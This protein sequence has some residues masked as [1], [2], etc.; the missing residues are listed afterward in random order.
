MLSNL[1]MKLPINKVTS[2]GFKERLNKTSKL[3]LIG[4]PKQIRHLMQ[5]A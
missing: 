4:F 3:S 2:K 5:K 1:S